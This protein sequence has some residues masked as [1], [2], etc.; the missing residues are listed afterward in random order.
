MSNSAAEHN[1]GDAAETATVSRRSNRV[2]GQLAA[3]TGMSLLVNAIPLPLVPDR[4][5][6]QLRG[7][8]AH[9]AAS[10][11]GV[12]LTSDAR[13]LLANPHTSDGLRRLFRKS[14]QMLARRLLRRLGPLAPLS[15]AIATFEVF[16][17]GHLLDRYFQH[18]R[19]GGTSRLQEREARIVREAVDRAILYTFHP[20]TDPKQLLLPEGAEDLRDE[21]TRWLDRLLLTSASLPNYVVR[22]L[23]AA[24]DDIIRRSS[25]ATD[26]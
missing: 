9:E 18:Q 14:A 25:D 12:T 5:L 19:S 13:S 2:G 8:V 23:D 10:R 15:T 3:L 20:S 21:F 26:G 17:L 1:N 4:I 24:F 11:H 7:A 16:A 22:R 6:A